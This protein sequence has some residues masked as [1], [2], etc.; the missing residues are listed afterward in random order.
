MIFRVPI[1]ICEAP[2][3]YIAIEA[4][5]AVMRECD[6]IGEKTALTAYALDWFSVKTVR[7]IMTKLYGNEQINIADFSME[8]YRCALSG[9]AVA[10]EILRDCATRLFEMASVVIDKCNAK[11]IGTYGGV[12]QKNSIVRQYF[13]QKIGQEYKDIRVVEERISAEESAAR[14]AREKIKE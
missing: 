5:R 4:L 13:L 11:Q 7:D 3:D 9:D 12:L 1:V 8:V 6:G 10:S 14:Y 2:K